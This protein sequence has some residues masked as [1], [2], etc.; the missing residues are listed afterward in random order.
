MFNKVLGKVL[1]HLFSAIMNLQVKKNSEAVEKTQPALNL[2]TLPVTN[3][4]NTTTTTTAKM[5]N[6][7]LCIRHRIK[8]LNLMSRV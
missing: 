1:S 3:L 4:V 6:F 7:I 8:G 5:L 2:V